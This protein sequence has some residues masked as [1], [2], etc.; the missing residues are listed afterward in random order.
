MLA[1]SDDRPA[2]L[3]RVHEALT[4]LSAEDRQRLGVELDGHLLTYRQVEYTFA[5]VSKALKKTKADGSPSEALWNIVVALVEASIP[6][7]HKDASSSLA[8]DWS[9]HE[10]FARPPLADQDSADPEA[11]WGH[12]S[13]GPTKGEL[14]F[15]YFLQAA[16]MVRDENGPEICELV[17]AM[18]LTTCSLDPVPA[19]V[20]VLERLSASGVEI[21]D[22]LSDSG[23]AHRRAEHWALPVR[24]LGG[25]I[26]TD[27]HPHDRGTR[28][29]HE[30][31][32]CFNGNLYCP[33]TPAAL[34]EIEPLARNASP[35]RT[36][37]H[38]ER[39]A[40]LARYKLG[41]IST[42]DADG[43][44]R[45]MCPAEMAKLRCVAKPSSL[46]FG[47]DRPQVSSPPVEL[48]KCCSQAS[49]TV[50]PEVNAK[51][52]QKHDYP[53][54]AHRQSY[55]RR[56]AVERSYS[57]LKDPASTD[58]TR[59][60]CRV[61]GLPAVT[62]MLVCAVVVRNFRVIDAFEERQLERERRAKAGLPPK[63]RRRRRKTID[64]LVASPP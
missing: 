26:V 51:T 2:H 7:S 44:H 22:V 45:V 62:L 43:Y 55:A 15:G 21:G 50:G 14:F 33:A 36:K 27:L 38:D 41:R 17:R 31:A 12:R 42:D 57:T 54:R 37:S 18:L 16:T 25:R 3:S 29:T 34:F 39:S 35:E 13:A 23:Y 56:T 5:V 30:G 9:D 63:T 53:S 19:F 4:E 6:A 40:E 52:A 59:G 49:I 28:G 48:P 32:I 20:P 24:A 1:L 46:L 10:S 61:M 64:D 11:S 47:F 60:W 58:T 8:V